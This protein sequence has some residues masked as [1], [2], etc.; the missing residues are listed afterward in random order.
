MPDSRER[1]HF[2]LKIQMMLG[3]LMVAVQGF[4]S[5]ELATNIQRAQE[6]CRR[7]GETPEIFGVLAALWSFDHANGQLRESRVLADRLLTMAGAHADR[8]RDGGR[9]ECD[10]SV[11][12]VAGRISSGARTSG[13]RRRGLRPR[14]AALRADDAGAGDAVALQ[15]CMGASY[16]RIPRPGEAPDGRGE[17]NGAAASPS[18]QRRVCQPVRDRADAFPTRVCR[19]AA[20]VGGADRTV[21]R[22]WT[23][24]L[25]GGGR[26]VPG[27]HDRRRRRV[28]RR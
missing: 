4:S 5:P 23:S 6:L 22:K 12:P 19:G 3:P 28:S 7:A 14:P 25:A 21:A 15:S 2:E 18:L 17:R 13:D 11:V 27:A 20:P 1:D 16:V 10:G 8:S 26:D 24:V 9:A